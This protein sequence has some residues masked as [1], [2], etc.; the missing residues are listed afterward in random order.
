[1]TPQSHIR[2]TPAAIADL[3]RQHRRFVI[4]THIN[5]DGDGLGSELAVAHW[6]VAHGRDVAIL[7]HSSTPAVYRF[8]DPAGLIRTYDDSADRGAIL[9]AD[10]ILVLDTNHPDRLGSLEPAVRESAAV[11][12]VIDH[13]L[14]PAP[15]AD[16]YLLDQDATSTGEIVYR[17]AIDLWGAELPPETATALFCAIMTDTGSFRYPRV[18]PETFQICAHLVQ[19][20][21]DPVAIYSEVYERWSPGRIHLLGVMLK[22]LA[23]ECEGRLAH[24]A[25]SR[26]DLHATGTTEEDTDN[27][28]TYPMSIRGVAAGILFLELP[29]EVKISFR[30]RGSIPINEL[31]KE[32]GGNGH[33]NA[34][35]ARVVGLPLDDVRARVVA[36]AAK[37]VR[38]ELP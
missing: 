31:A 12:V 16:Q 19:C 1:M 13:H 5:P 18:D 34:A 20:G 36:A 9:G 24:V 21:A 22:G 29:G 15:F 14:D 27:F 6:L 7:N 38:E 10:A 11:K 28:T 25:I 26:A 30:S 3:L 37:Y 17:I 35:G 23:V 33:R 4:T 8:L 2:A 32:F